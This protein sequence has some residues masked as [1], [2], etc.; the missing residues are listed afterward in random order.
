MV[1]HVTDLASGGGAI[2]QPGRPSTEMACHEAPLLNSQDFQIIS[3]YPIQSQYMSTS[4][5]PTYY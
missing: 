3:D 1:A 4:F 2:G 5:I